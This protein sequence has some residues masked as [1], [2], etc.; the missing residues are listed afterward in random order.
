VEIT[1]GSRAVRKKGPVTRDNMI[2]I[3]V[4]IIVR[5]KLL[6][7]RPAVYRVSQEERT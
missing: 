1:A 5:L 7:L 6:N 2:A 4:T 3:I